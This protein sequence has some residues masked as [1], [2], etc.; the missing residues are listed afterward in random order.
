VLTEFAQ[1]NHDRIARMLLTQMPLHDPGELDLRSL[2]EARAA[3]PA[4]DDAPDFYEDVHVSLRAESTPPPDDSPVM[5][6]LL[7]DRLSHRIRQRDGI[8]R[9]LRAANGQSS[10]PADEASAAPIV[11]NASSEA[12]AITALQVADAR[13]DQRDNPLHRTLGALDPEALLN[14]C[15]KR[16]EV[17]YEKLAQ[18]VAKTDPQVIAR[19]TL[20]Y[21]SGRM[22]DILRALQVP[23]AIVHGSDDP[24]VAE[25][26]ED[27]LSYVT[28]GK[29]DMLVPFTLPGV[30]HFPMLESD[31][32]HQI[33]GGFL[34]QQ[35]LSKI[36]IRSRWRRRAR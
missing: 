33:V 26:S 20:S 13:G 10:S 32:F 36:A 2:P 15:F 34:E 28:A 27:V 11:P 16:S 3:E 19:S 22:L 24:L 18:D 14:R 7:L 29:E 5:S 35:D 9:P 1:K 8:A 30:R 4:P 31:D 6:S 23:V 17:F 21:D 25:P 12:P